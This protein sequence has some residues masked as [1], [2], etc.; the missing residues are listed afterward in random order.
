MLLSTIASVFSALLIT[1][2]TLAALTPQ[3]VVA[4]I[5]VVTTLSADAN[6]ALSLLSTSTTPPDVTSINGVS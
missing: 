6:T 5:Q 4:G 3:Q 1:Q 2:G